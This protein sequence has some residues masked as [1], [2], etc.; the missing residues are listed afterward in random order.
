MLIVQLFLNTFLRLYIDVEKEIKNQLALD[1]S[2]GSEIQNKRYVLC[3]VIHLSE[4]YSMVL[5]NLAHNIDISSNTIV[6][7]MRLSVNDCEFYFEERYFQKLQKCKEEYNTF[8]PL[9]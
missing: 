4:K 9:Y 8:F 1:L 7:S 3:S 2:K 5:Y 6:I